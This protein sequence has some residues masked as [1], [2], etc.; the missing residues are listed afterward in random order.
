MWGKNAHGAGRKGQGATV[1]GTCEGLEDPSESCDK[2]L[3]WEGP[4]RSG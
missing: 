1:W 2:H 3:R 4:S